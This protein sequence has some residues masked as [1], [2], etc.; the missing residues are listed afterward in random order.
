MT[1]P[2][3]L[4]SFKQGMKKRLRE[5]L[6]SQEVWNGVKG[7]ENVNLVVTENLA[8]SLAELIT[9]QTILLSGV[10]MVQTTL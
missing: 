6:K 4:A 8:E 7:K 5:S 9:T 3:S 10:V 1:K 2:V